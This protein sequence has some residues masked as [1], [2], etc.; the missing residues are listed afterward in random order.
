MI[1]DTKNVQSVDMS[2]IVKDFPGVRAVDDVDLHLK[3]G[4]IHALLGENGAGKSTLMKILYGL[5]QADGGTIRVNGQVVDVDSPTT[6]IEHGIGMIH[7]HFMLVP[8]LTVTE[9]VA[10]GLREGGRMRLD[11]RGV[12]DRLRALS[13]QYNLHVD[14]DVPV[15]QLSV[16]ERQRVEILRA[17]FKG[18][19]LLILDEP[20][21]VLTPQEAD[22]LLDTLRGM[23]EIG[24][25]IVFISHKLNEVI[26]LADEITVLRAGKHIATIP[27]EGATKPQLAEL[28]VGHPVLF[29][30][31]KPDVTINE[32]RLQVRDV[33]ARR[34]R[35]DEGLR[36]VSFEVCAGEIVGVAGVSGN[37]QH[38]LAEVITGLRRAEAG[39]VRIDGNDVTNHSPAAIKR[40]GTAYIPEER[41]VDGIVKDFSV[42]DNYVLRDY[43]REDYTTWGWLVRHG[44]IAEACKRAIDEFAIKT[45]GTRVQAKNLSGGNIQKLVLA[46]ELSTEPC[47]VVAA[48]PT[49]GVDIGAI[50]YI[51]QRLLAEKARGA[52]ILLISEDLDEVLL[53]ADR[54]LVIYEGQIVGNLPREGVEMETLGTMMAGATAV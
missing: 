26:K 16:G 47:V 52:A 38:E 9:N 6:A 14:P 13:D 29:D 3:A 27:A 1:G 5:Y 11:R 36:G 39:A 49:R 54:I 4:E 50:E 32:P 7:Q 41:M 33:H 21:A 48:Q 2:G 40:L 23:T 17:L 22:A 44:R 34:D 15:W 28:M 37:G 43:E 51:H 24:H 35:G 46:R 42:A 31:E 18:T 8:S 53:L 45:P 25:T 12:S 19:D 20:T 10:L 30:Y